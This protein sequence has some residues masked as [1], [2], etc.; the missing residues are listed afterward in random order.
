MVEHEKPDLP[1]S[2]P[3]TRCSWW[4]QVN[5]GQSFWVVIIN[6]PLAKMAFYG[7]KVEQR[8]RS[9]VLCTIEKI[10]CRILGKFLSLPGPRVP[11]LQRVSGQA[12]GQ[13]HETLVIHDAGIK[14]G[15]CGE[16]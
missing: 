12:R 7:K 16:P 15:F 1:H 13:R 6:S 8:G 9:P 10:S 11:H 3:A 5:P 4:K 2:C 14:Q